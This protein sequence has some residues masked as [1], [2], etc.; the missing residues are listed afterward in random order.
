M[1]SVS[2]FL[3]DLQL[4]SEEDGNISLQQPLKTH[5]NKWLILDSDVRVFSKEALLST[6]TV[7][8]CKSSAASRAQDGKG[9]QEERAVLQV[10]LPNQK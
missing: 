7:T 6:G 3:T 2:L 10:A 9:W 4:V 1:V 5:R 8:F